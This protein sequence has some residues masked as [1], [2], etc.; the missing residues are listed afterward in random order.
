MCG[1]RSYSAIAFWGRNYGKKL[2]QALG[3][4]RETPPGA[5]TC[6]NVCSHL[7]LKLLE[8]LLAQ[9]AEMILTSPQTAADE[10][11]TQAIAIDGKTLR[12]SQKQGAP[13]CHLLSA[14][15]HR[16]GLTLFQTAAHRKTHEIPVIIDV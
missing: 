14:V 12:G 15:S 9:W 5:A 16:L 3:L 11:T 4:T 13:I 7:D 10:I 8:L 1:Y 6:Y 2:A